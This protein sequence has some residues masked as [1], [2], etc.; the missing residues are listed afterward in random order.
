MAGV[1][2]YNIAGK[3]VGGHYVCHSQL[4]EL[5]GGTYN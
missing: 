1:A 2:Y 5:D 3:Q 4:L